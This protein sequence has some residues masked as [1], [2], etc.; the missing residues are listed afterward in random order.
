MLGELSHIGVKN[1]YLR[2]YSSSGPE[3]HFRSSLNHFTTSFMRNFKET[4]RVGNDCIRIVS[5]NSG[6][7]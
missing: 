3:L 5:L 2:S 6:Y 4:V 7:H 1:T